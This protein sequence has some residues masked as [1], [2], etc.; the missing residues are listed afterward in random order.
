MIAIYRNYIGN[1]SL[2]LESMRCILLRS[3]GQGRRSN[4]C[5]RRRTIVEAATSDL[6]HWTGGKVVFLPGYILHNVADHGILY[7]V[8]ER[9]LLPCSAGDEEGH[10]PNRRAPKPDGMRRGRRAI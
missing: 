3:E 5:K 9:M 4:R 7:G 10:H 2:T 8:N 1:C 6:E